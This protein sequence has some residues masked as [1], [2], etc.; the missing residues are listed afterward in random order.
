MGTNTNAE[1][2]NN[3]QLMMMMMMDQQMPN[4][5]EH[6]QQQHQAVM[7]MTP[8]EQVSMKPTR[9]YSYY[10]A[11]NF[12]PFDLSV[13]CQQLEERQEQERAA[14]AAEATTATAREKSPAPV[15]PSRREASRSSKR[16]SGSGPGGGKKQSSGS[17][18]KQNKRLST[19]LSDIKASHHNR[20]TV[21]DDTRAGAEN[22]A[23]SS[24][25]RGDKKSKSNQL[26]VDADE[27]KNGLR[28]AKKAIDDDHHRSLSVFKRATGLTSTMPAA[29]ARAKNPIRLLH[30][31]QQQ[32]Q[33]PNQPNQHQPISGKI[34]RFFRHLFR[35]GDKHATPSTIDEDVRYILLYMI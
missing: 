26:M 34:N 32:E 12:H 2:F 4:A 13:L 33:Q 7:M 19:S 8:N 35:V 20:L 14:A 17:S 11:T 21:N 24:L 30:Q 22:A 27:S 15:E 18:K 6:Q 9:P 28:A 31:Q 10:V 5:M 1:E 16:G 3:N 29:F 23:T 25:L